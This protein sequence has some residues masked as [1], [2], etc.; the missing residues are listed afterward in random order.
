MIR[1]IARL[2]MGNDIFKYIPDFFHCRPLFGY[3]FY[4]ILTLN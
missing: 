4:W 1:A 3:I 2:G